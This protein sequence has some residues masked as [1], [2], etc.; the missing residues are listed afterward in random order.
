[1]QLTS[2]LP[3]LETTIFTKMSALAKEHNALNL[4]Q[5]FPNFQGDPK[6]ISL[7]TKAMQEGQNQYAPMMGNPKLLEAISNKLANSYNVFYHPENEIMVT[8]GASQAI[9]SAITAFVHKDDEVII[10]KPA[11]DCYEPAVQLNGGRVVD[12]QL[13][14]PSY[15]IDWEDVKSEINP[16]TRMIIVNS[17]TNPTGTIFTEE[18]MLQLQEITKGT[19]VVI[20][21]DEVYEHMIYDGQKHQS[22]MLFP[23][24]Q[25]RCVL[26]FSFGKTF[27]HTGWK[28][29]YCCAPKELMDEIVKV[30]M[31]SIFS[32]NHPVQIALAEYLNDS[33]HY[34]YLNDFYQQK[35]DLFLD[36]VKDSKFTYRPAQGTYFQILNYKTISD[37]ND[38]K[39]AERL[40]KENGIASIPISVFNK[41]KLDNK[42][43]R[44]CFAK[45][46]DTLKRAAEILNAIE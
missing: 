21:S 32:V 37:E 29:G 30:H 35:R 3:N 36:L 15:R 20:L 28:T 4:S 33:E 27:H 41:D 17:P 11:Y 23:D 12:I 18:D 25:K 1:M 44:F 16:K 6:I 5:G 9:F 26:T 10:F 38:V 43:L 46:D 2:K 34:E 22:A 24:L 40:T 13:Y 14:G 19:D 39:F 45:K 7:V 31:F 42:D 8:V